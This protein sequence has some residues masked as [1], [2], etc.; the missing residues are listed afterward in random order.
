MEGSNYPSRNMSVSSD[1][2]PLLPKDQTRATPSSP[3]SPQQGTYMTP[4][5]TT[6]GVLSTKKAPVQ[7]TYKKE[8]RNRNMIMVLMD[9]ENQEKA[10]A[11]AKKES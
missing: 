8:H 5:Y 1:A 6:K 3:K 7:R 4:G 9:A 11:Q 10:M 2:A